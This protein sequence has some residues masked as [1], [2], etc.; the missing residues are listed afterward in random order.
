M[1]K[2]EFIKLVLVASIISSCNNQSG[3]QEKN[4]FMR[5]DT[6]ARYSHV[7]QGSHG[8]YIPFIAYGL[9]SGNRFSRAGYFSNAIH[10]SS[11]IGTNSS[12]GNVIR[13]GFG[14]SGSHVST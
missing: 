8:S 10:E 7:L 3:K 2:S 13:S 9:L 12:K 14:S 11:N 1:K 4:V 6:T 5:S